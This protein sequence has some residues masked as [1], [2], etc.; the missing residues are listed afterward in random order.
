ML[1]R[2]LILVLALSASELPAQVVLSELAANPSE[3]IVKWSA[4]GV[5]SIGSGTPW[6]AA[7]F[8]ASAWSTGNAPFGHGSAGLGTD[9]AAPISR[10]R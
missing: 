10:R 8:N 1:S 3:R 9:L 4:T 7:G 6:N 5:P 2:A